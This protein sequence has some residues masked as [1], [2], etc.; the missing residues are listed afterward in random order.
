[1]I[2]DIETVQIFIRTR[3]KSIGERAKKIA[4]KEKSEDK[5]N[6]NIN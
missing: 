3:T 5:T 6:G 2:G 1:M 4:E